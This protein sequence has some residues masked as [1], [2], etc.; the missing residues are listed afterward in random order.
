[1]GFPQRKP[2]EPKIVLLPPQE[3]CNMGIAKYALNRENVLFSPIH[4]P[5]YNSS[6]NTYPVPCGWTLQRK[7]REL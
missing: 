7:A 5:Y 6:L 4:S 2:C 3:G 1:V